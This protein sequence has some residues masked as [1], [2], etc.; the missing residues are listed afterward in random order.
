[1]RD[2]HRGSPGRAPVDPLCTMS[3]KPAVL[4]RLNFNEM[5]PAAERCEL[6]CALAP[7]DGFR[8]VMAESIARQRP[9]AEE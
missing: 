9:P 7:P 4:V 1:M 5:I 3:Q 2:G 6:D 8:S